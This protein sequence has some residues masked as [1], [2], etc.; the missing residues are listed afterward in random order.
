MMSHEEAVNVV[1]YLNRGGLLI[2][3]EGQPAVWRDA[4]WGVRYADAQEACR[5]LVREGG[6]RDRFAT[7][8][9]LL[10]AVR[11]IRGARIKDRV[12]P[13]P[14]VPLPAAAELEFGR[15]YLRALGDGATEEEADAAACRVAQ[16]VRVQVEAGP[17]PDLRELVEAL[18][19]PGED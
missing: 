14:P 19:V 15:A 4:L 8:A 13:A 3:S 16:V 7:P 5:V 9:D 10:R 2:A 17:V 11:R 12:P 1:A 6:T 18:K